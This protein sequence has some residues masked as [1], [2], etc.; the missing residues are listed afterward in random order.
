[1]MRLAWAFECYA[2]AGYNCGAAALTAGV[3]AAVPVQP[4]VQIEPER[5]AIDETIDRLEKQRA[6]DADATSNTRKTN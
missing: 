2:V 3:P 5:D 1:M 6:A 4:A